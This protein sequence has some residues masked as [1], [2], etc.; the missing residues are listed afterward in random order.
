[1]SLFLVSPEAQQDLIGIWEFIVRNSVDAGN[2]VVAEFYETFAS[3]G[4]MPDQSYRRTDLT[5]RLVQFESSR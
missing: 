4:R 5:K 3:L 2:R 1:M